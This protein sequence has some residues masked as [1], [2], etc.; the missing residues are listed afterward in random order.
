MVFPL[1]RE[2]KYVHQTF[3]G[4]ASSVMSTLRLEMLV[5][6]HTLQKGLAALSKHL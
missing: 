2:V 5:C 3:E 1:R 4:G 6:V